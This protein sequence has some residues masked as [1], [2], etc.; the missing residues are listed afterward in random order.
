MDGMRLNTRTLALLKQRPR[1]MTYTAIA[2]ATGLDV[3]WIK[4][5]AAGRH[6]D[7]MCDRIQTLWEYLTGT[8]LDLSAPLSLTHFA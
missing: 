4:A 6:K 7:G 3:G 8:K 2:D 1:T 5:F